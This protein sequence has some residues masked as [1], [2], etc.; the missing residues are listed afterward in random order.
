M[1][2]M[3]GPVV[4]DVAPMPMT[5][6]TRTTAGDFAEKPVLGARAPLEFVGNGPENWTV[7]AKL[8]PHRF[9]GG[10]QLNLL[11]VIRANGLPQI[12]V[13]GDGSMFGWFVVA[14][15]IERASYPDKSGVGRVIAVDITLRRAGMP[16]IG[17]VLAAIAALF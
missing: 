14:E 4:M 1:Q 7:R 9:G 10:A 15:V 3:I 11:S 8:Y 2:L 17:S 13:R 6:Y 5:E 12:V 16:G